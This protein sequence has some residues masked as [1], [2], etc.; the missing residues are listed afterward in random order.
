MNKQRSRFV[1]SKNGA[2]MGISDTI[3]RQRTEQEAVFP[4]ALINPV[5]EVA[6]ERHK[7]L[8]NRINIE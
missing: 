4:A 6:E 7:I 1:K 8:S 2:G 3:H 5:S